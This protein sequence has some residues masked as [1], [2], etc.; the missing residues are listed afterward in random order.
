MK[1]AQ[2]VKMHIMNNCLNEENKNDV[3]RS[4]FIFYTKPKQYH[5]ETLLFYF[6]SLS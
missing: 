3:L 1:L 4:S 2:C 5:I 6:I